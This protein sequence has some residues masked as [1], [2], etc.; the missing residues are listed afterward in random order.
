MSVVVIDEPL[1]R[2]LEALA[3]LTEFRDRQGRLLGRFSPV[4]SARDVRRA[5]DNCPYTDEQLD[6]MRNATSGRSLDEIK[7][8]WAST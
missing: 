1:Q 6:E 7:Q 4:L 3:G 2:E 5:S 8:D